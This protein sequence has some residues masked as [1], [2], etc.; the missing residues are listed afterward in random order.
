[1][2]QYTVYYPLPSYTSP[3]LHTLHALVSLSPTLLTSSLPQIKIQYIEA[4][5]PFYFAGKV[6]RFRILRQLCAFAP[7]L[8]CFLGVGPFVGL[9]KYFINRDKRL[10][11]RIGT[12]CTEY[13]EC[14]AFFSIRPN[15]VPP[16]PSPRKGVLL[17]PPLGP[18]GGR[19]TRLRR[20]EGRDPIPTKGQTSWYSM[21]TII[22]LR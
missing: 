6:A 2:S 19:H 16:T 1:M 15:W 10:M 4:K 5:F 3:T 18:R 21:Y 12:Y 11:F 14:Q 22:L 8:F 13:T 7:F 20:R 17:L 9:D